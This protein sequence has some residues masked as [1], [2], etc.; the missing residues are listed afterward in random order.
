MRPPPTRRLASSSTVP[1]AALFLS[2]CVPA[3]TGTVEASIFGGNETDGHPEV[4]WV[5][6]EDEFLCST[7]LVAPT[8]ALTAA[9]CVYGYE[10]DPGVLSV[11]FASGTDR[12]PSAEGI[13]VEAIHFAPDYTTLPAHDLAAMSLAVEAPTAPVPWRA[14]PL[15]AENLGDGLRLVGFG[16]EAVGEA[17]TDPVRREAEVVLEDLENVTVRWFSE[18][19][20]LCYGDSGGAVF[21]VDPNGR[22]LELAAIATEGDAGCDSRGAGVRTDTFHEFLTDPG[23]GDDDVLGDDDGPSEFDPE[24]MDACGGCAQSVGGVALLPA[25]FWSGRLR[26]RR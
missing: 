9:H 16:I 20:G 19:A 1:L 13:E 23:A 25:L 7:V 11:V 22:H 26:R 10:N 14:A 18:D 8:R 24:D 6:F 17:V 12:P 21:L 5:S 15:T 4:G 2:G 3:A